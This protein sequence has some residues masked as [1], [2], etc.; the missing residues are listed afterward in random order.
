VVKKPRTH[1]DNLKVSRTA[2]QDDIRKAY[3]RLVSA[4]HPDRNRHPL[5]VARM[6][7][8]NNA[9]EVL[10]CT[11]SRARHDAWI[12]EQETPPVRPASPPPPKPEPQPQAERHTQYARDPEGFDPAHKAAFRAFVQEHSRNHSSDYFELTTD[13]LYRKF[14]QK[15]EAELK[16]E[17]EADLARQLREGPFIDRLFEQMRNIHGVVYVLIGFVVALAFTFL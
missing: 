17:Y 7:V 2:S 15:L 5:S 16:A 9:Y 1:Y 14:L 11:D 8:I 3:R 12:A 10:S 6:K 4:H 13:A